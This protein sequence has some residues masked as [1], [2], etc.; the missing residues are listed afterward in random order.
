MSAPTLAVK[1]GPMHLSRWATGPEERAGDL[2][3]LGEHLSGF[4]LGRSRETEV[5][6]RG[7]A[8]DGCVVADADGGNGD[9]AGAGRRAALV[10]GLRAD[11][12]GGR[13]L[14]VT[15][16]EAADL[17]VAAV[18]RGWLPAGRH[19]ST[20]GHWTHV[21]RTTSRPRALATELVTAL[22]VRW[23]TVP[24]D[25]GAVGLGKHLAR[26][27]VGATVAGGI[28]ID[29]REAGVW[30]V[31]PLGPTRAELNDGAWA[32]ETLG[33]L[34]ADAA[35]GRRM[36]VDAGEVEDLLLLARHRGWLAAGTYVVGT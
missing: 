26:H 35:A 2:V 36:A 15:E 21:P 4:V 25:G 27:V 14:V 28:G 11:A 10:D 6:I 32:A 7:M 1:A 33:R 17:V 20:F 34:R 18:E 5:A 12:A 13:R 16:A 19:A 23:D 8:D 24:G 3:G 29:G 31:V 9:V 30:W 22:R